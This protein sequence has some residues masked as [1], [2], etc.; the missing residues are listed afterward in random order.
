[1]RFESPSPRKSAFNCPH[2]HALAQQ[3]WYSSIAVPMEEKL[4]KVMTWSKVL[5]AI[6]ESPR[7]NMTD[8]EMK[9]F[10][11]ISEGAPELG[12]QTFGDGQVITNIWIGECCNCSKISI[13]QHENMIYP[14]A[15]NSPPP[16]DD[17]PE[18]IKADYREAALVLEHSP[19]SAAALVR[20]AIEKLC[21]E[22]GQTTGDLNS[23]IAA[24]ARNGLDERARMILDSVRVIGNEAVHPGS[25]DLRDDR[26]TATRL[27]EALNFLADKLI[28]QPREA[29]ALYNRIPEEKRRAIE[30]R[31][32]TK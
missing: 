32:S 8:E 18:D 7:D 31:D 9:F 14:K 10:I 26:E 3:F 30:K 17:L 15:F 28:S 24:L 29:E 27:L 5:G 22:L 20:L 4:P 19:R 23:K 21:C 13:W 16:N 25:I 2:C 12:S 11:A 6:S 1:M